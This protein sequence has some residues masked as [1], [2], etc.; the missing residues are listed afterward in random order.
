M[1]GIVNTGSFGK[2][3]WPGINSWYGKKYSEF[4]VE[5]TNLF[6][7]N[8]TNRHYEEDVGTVG[9]GLAKVKGEGEAVEYEGERQ[10]F[11]TRYIPVEY[12]LGFIITE[13]MM[14]DDLYNIVGQKRSEALAY[15]VWW[16]LERAIFKLA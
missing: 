2:A 10:G 7:K 1:T 8:T 16:L 15:K 3:L 9:M 11:I 14:E 13:I 4:P 5:F 6:D 12:A